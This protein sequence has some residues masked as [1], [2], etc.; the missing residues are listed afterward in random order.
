[1]GY[2][3]R[4]S[5]NDMGRDEHQ[6]TASGGGGSGLPLVCR[7]ARFGLERDGAEGGGKHR[8]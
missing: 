6:T 2:T 1:M 3:L 5:L 4:E 8:V 7:A